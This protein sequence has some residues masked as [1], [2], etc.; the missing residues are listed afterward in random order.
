MIVHL[1]RLKDYC[2]PSFVACFH[3]KE[4]KPEEKSGVRE[5]VNP[6]CFNSSSVAELLYHLQDDQRD[7]FRP[8]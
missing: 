6:P 5:D 7:V 4:F 8:R 3:H 1:I 2:G